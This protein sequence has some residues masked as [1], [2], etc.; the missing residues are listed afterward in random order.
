VL[1]HYGL[2]STVLSA[3]R[4]MHLHST[5][6][7]PDAAWSLAIRSNLRRCRYARF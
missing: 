3:A 4:W 5:M 2:S 6:F 7:D 1:V